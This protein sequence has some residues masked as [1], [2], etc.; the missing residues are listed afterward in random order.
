MGETR[1]Q[2]GGVLPPLPSSSEL[3]L[4]WLSLLAFLSSFTFLFFFGDRL[5][6]L[7][8]QPLEHSLLRVGKQQQKMNKKNNNKTAHHAPTMSQNLVIPKLRRKD[9]EKLEASSGLYDDFKAPTMGHT[10]LG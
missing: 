3:E 10:V 4:G 1:D 9:Q 5:R 8:L 7:L 2:L 6:I